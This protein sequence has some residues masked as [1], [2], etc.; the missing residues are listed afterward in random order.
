LTG[1]L[2]PPEVAGRLDRLRAGFDVGGVDALVVTNPTNIR[3]LTGFTGS[4]GEL[5]VGADAALLVTDGRYAEQAP[6]QVAESGTEVAIA[7]TDRRSLVV[8]RLRG[9]DRVGLEAGSVTW[10]EQRRLADWFDGSGLVATEGLVEELRQVKDE[11]EVA[12]IEAA[13]AIAD[14]ALADAV[15]LLAVGVSERDVAAAI[16]HG[17]R[18][19]GADDRAFVTIVAAGPNSALPHARPTDRTLR[20]GDL[21]VCDFGS[22]VDGYRSDMTRSFRMG[23]RAGGQEDEM[24]DAVRAAQAAGLASVADGVPLAEVDAACRGVLADADLADAFLHG[25]G[26]G[27]GLDIHEA[28]TLSGSATGTLRTGHV[29][30]VEPGAYLAG[31]GGVRWED[32]VLVTDDGHR[33]LTRAPRA[34]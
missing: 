26:H 27:V 15:E 5:L 6:T 8:D 23:G 7:G 28:P 33:A 16:D 13:A 19:R 25:T 21:V 18:T 11:G 12:R 32:T 29:V 9:S 17:I 2:P 14:A 1:G 4:A 20:E 3:Y 31:L 34:D 24:R 22:V 10:S 30:T